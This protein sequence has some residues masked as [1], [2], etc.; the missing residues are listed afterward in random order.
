MSKIGTE[1]V[2]KLSKLARIK[3]SDEE[4]AQMSV[5]LG[6][7]VEFVEQLQEVDVDGVDTTNQ[8]TGL[9]DVWRPD[10]VRPKNIERDE[11]FKNLPERQGDYIKVKRVL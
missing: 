3:L 5:E 10:V 8:V 11:L 7:I 1:E 2:K 9:T 6:Q 4:V